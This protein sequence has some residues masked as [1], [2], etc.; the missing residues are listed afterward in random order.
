[1]SDLATLA[2]V[3]GF[4][5]VT[6]PDFDTLFERLIDAATAR[7]ERVCG[8]TFGAADH[9]EWLTSRLDDTVQVRNWPILRVY[10]VKHGYEDA[11]TLTYSGDDIEAL[12]EVGTDNLYLRSLAAD[13]TS[14]ETTLAF[15]TYP[16]VSTLVAAADAV[17]GWTAAT[18]QDARA[19]YLHP[20]AGQAAK[21]S[22]SGYNVTL[23]FADQS[24]NQYRVDAATGILGWTY[25]DSFDVATRPRPTQFGYGR[26]HV[27]YSAPAGYRRV[28]VHYRG[29]FETVPADVTQVALEMIQAAWQLGRRDSS[30]TSESLGDYSY[31]LVDRIA[32]DDGQ[33]EKLRPYMSEAVA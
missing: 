25:A 6:D 9:Y 10:A 24:D 3:K 23:S 12:V 4:L 29:G 21:E 7:V 14:T 26:V 8:R 32:L 33:R 18:L 22:G 1:M 2:E 13:G 16:T 28:L 27:T 11:M 5:N 30:V 31:N 17:S 20:V 19:T 15:A